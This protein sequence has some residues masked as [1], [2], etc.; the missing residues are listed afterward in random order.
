MT[1][2]YKILTDDESW[3]FAE[4]T[5]TH[6]FEKF[7]ARPAEENG[8]RGWRFD[9]WAPGARSVRLTGSWCDWDPN[10]HF[11]ESTADTAGVWHLFMPGLNE[12]ESYKYVIEARDGRLLYKA[13]PYGC[14]CETPPETASR[15]ADLNNFTWSDGKWMAARAKGDRREKPLNIYEVHLGSWR[16]H[17][18]GS[19]LSYRELAGTLVP[20][21]VELGYTHLEIMPVMEH[22]F[23]GSWGYQ[24]TGYYA[25]TSRYGAPT[26]FMYFVNEAHRAGLGVILDWAPAHFCRDA[27]GLGEFVGEPLYE[28]GS[29][30]Q[31]G[32]YKFNV[33][34]GEVRSFLISNCVYWLEK[35]HADGIRMDG[36]TSML[37]LNFGIDDERLKKHAADGTEHDYDSIA[38]IQKINATVSREY[39]DVMMIAEESTAWPLVTYPPEDGG[40]G[41]HFKWDMGWMH[42]TLNYMKTDFPYRPAHHG[43]LTFSMM[44]A[45]NENFVLALSHDEVVHGKASLIGKMPGDYWRQFAG[46]RA[47]L[48]YQT[49]HSGAKHNFMGAELAQFIEWRYYEGLEWFLLD[50]DAHRKHQTYVKELNHLF[51]R[52]KALWQKN[53]SWDG[54]EWLD[55]DDASQ[56]ILTFIRHGKVPTEDLTCLLSFVP[57]VYEEFR[58]GV[59]RKGT[60]AEIFNS[61]DRRFGGSGRVNGQ[62]LEAE[63]IPAHGKKYS[64]VVRTPPIGGLVLKRL[65]PK[66]INN[67]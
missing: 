30:P 61:D 15:L 22:P 55:A 6:A 36:V 41:F 10:R 58:I 5:W 29:H 25:P 46:L 7:G 63:K 3:E 21:A 26:D 67:K 11:M 47:L 62:L 19:M 24:L 1:M 2:D 17:E 43:G 60:Y 18:D 38:L 66:R 48:L 14:Y 33:K 50:Y 8:I 52:E 34:K 37:Y 64:V 45:F 23:D 35:Y 13:D 44:Y 32:T 9:V 56:C 40:L 51:L 49:L 4:G 12:G 53:F 31:W 27:H 28:G 54:F 42:D 59:P 57:E 16:R 65:P 39:P 20:Y